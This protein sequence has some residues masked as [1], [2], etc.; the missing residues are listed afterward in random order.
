MDNQT[1]K[2]IM[3]KY[4]KTRVLGQR[5]TQISKGA[6]PLVDIGDLDDAMSI[7]EKELLERKIPLKIKRFYPDGQ[8]LEIPVSSMDT[9][10]F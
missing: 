6:I 2:Y 8:T 4:E 1:T 7:A 5:A 10:N 3:T 9:I